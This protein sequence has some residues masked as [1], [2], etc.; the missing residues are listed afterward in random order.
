[1]TPT[2]ED[3][4]RRMTEVMRSVF[5]EPDLAVSAATTARDIE[6]WDSLRNVEL[7]VA[8]QSEF[9]IRF[10]TGEMTALKNAGELA[11]AIVRKLNASRG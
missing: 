10:T 2:A 11:A 6:A 9:G 3:V 7:M 1:M 5:E 8:L 4:F